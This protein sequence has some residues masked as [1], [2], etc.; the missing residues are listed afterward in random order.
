[1]IY[2]AY[3]ADLNPSR[4]TENSPGHKSIGVAR[5]RDWWITF[6]RYSP[7]ER[8]ATVSI[9]RQE[10]EAVWGVLY[11]VPDWDIPIL[12]RIFGFDPDGPLSLNEH[13]R[14][15]VAVERLGR[16]QQVVANTFIAVPDDRGARP[17]VEYMMQIVDGAR[18]HG[19]PRAY[20]GALQAMRTGAR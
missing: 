5:L 16:P 6:P 1:M 20:L 7:V 4:M 17:T 13:I 14:R 10:G 9:A 12:D 2:F 18:Y 8:S 15:D 11:E 3:G 19:L